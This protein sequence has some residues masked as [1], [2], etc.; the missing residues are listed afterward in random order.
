M[1][2]IKCCQEASRMHSVDHIPPS[3]YDQMQGEMA[4]LSSAL[5]RRVAWC[6]F[7]VWSPERHRC[8]RVHF[9]FDYFHTFV[10]PRLRVFYFRFY[11]PVAR[12]MPLG[13]SGS[14]LR[15][16]ARQLAKDFERKRARN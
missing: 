5:Q 1:G 9:D 10:L 11:V 14:G 8:A 12:G 3:Y 13:A 6:D 7:W 16:R 15:R 2:E 4:I